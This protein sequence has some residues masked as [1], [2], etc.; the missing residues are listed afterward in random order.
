MLFSRLFIGSKFRLVGGC[1]GRSGMIE[2]F[3]PLG[4]VSEL[5]CPLVNLEGSGRHPSGGL[6]SIIRGFQPRERER[7]LLITDYS[8]P[9]S[10]P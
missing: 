9:A 4:E 2:L 6:I 1:C 8:S 10:S 3:K 7:S 5:G